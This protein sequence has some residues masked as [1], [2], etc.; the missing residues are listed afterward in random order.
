MDIYEN[1]VIGNFLYCLGMAIGK[2][3][4]KALPPLAVNLL[5]QTPLDRSVG[6]VLLRGAN[7]LRVLEF[8]RKK[9]DHYKEYAKLEH[10]SRALSVENNRDL[11]P[12]SRQV[13]WFLESEGAD[14]QFDLKI[15]PYLDFRRPECVSIDFTAFVNGI[16]AGMRTHNYLAHQFQRYLNT[17]AASQG[18]NDSSSGGLVVTVDETGIVRY[19]VVEDLRELALTLTQLHSLYLQRE[20]VNEQTQEHTRERSYDR[21]YSR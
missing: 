13:H 12:L 10:L 18:A 6:D 3:G 17:L 20:K 5:Q 8:K 15:V 9:S 4:D 19:I 7:V 2:L 11:I 1:I 16:V 21:G 14:G